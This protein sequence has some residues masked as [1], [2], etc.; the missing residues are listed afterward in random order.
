MSRSRSRCFR[1]LSSIVTRKSCHDQTRPQASEQTPK[2]ISSS[3]L[4]RGYASRNGIRP[5]CL[6]LSLVGAGVARGDTGSRNH[7]CSERLALKTV[8]RSCFAY[9]RV[10]LRVTLGMKPTPCGDGSEIVGMLSKLHR[11][12]LSRRMRQSSHLTRPRVPSLLIPATPRG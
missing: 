9:F 4:H 7:R 8:A 5:S 3:A 11:R 10:I 1:S 6:S 12:K 2:Q